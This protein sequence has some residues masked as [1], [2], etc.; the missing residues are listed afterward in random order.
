MYA[1][2]HDSC[3]VARLVSC[4]IAQWVSTTVSCPVAQGKKNQPRETNG[5]TTPLS[6]VPRIRA[7]I[8]DYYPASQQVSC[9]VICY[10][11]FDFQITLLIVTSKLTHDSNASGDMQT[12]NLI[13]L[14]GCD[15]LQNSAVSSN[16]EGWLGIN[17]P[18]YW[19]IQIFS[20]FQGI[21]LAA[22]KMFSD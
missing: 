11:Y 14:E 22:T 2:S 13:E 6:L 20:D 1:F 18:Y 16:D 3:P 15:H 12:E 8:R 4:P 7:W 10:C 17:I 19:W 9:P 21:N 5:S